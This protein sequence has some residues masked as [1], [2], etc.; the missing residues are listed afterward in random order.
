MI[1]KGEVEVRRE[2]RRVFVRMEGEYITDEELLRRT[3]DREHELEQTRAGIGAE[4]I[5]VDAQSVRT[6]AGAGRG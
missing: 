4:S 1:R 2:G 3:I 5:G 6:G